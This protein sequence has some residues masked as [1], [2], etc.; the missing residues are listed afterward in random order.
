MN[1]AT[2]Y[3]EFPVEDV[4]VIADSGDACADASKFRV[5]RVT[6]WAD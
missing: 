5:C 6:I 1:A 4:R 3:V 2:E